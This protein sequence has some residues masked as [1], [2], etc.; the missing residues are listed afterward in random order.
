MQTQLFLNELQAKNVEELI[1]SKFI[2]V[3]IIYKVGGLDVYFPKTQILAT[4]ATFNSFL[5]FG[6]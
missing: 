6:P 5:I 1:P 4:I 2:Q 3:V